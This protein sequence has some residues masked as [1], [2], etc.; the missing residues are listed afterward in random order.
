MMAAAAIPI[1]ATEL[2]ANATAAEEVAVVSAVASAVF[3]VVAL[4]L[5]Y[6]EKAD[7]YFDD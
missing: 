1:T 7:K 3:W 6:G 5:L 2:A 4:F